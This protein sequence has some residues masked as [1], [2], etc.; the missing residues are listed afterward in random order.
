[1]LAIFQ[2]RFERNLS[3]V[4]YKMDIFVRNAVGGLKEK[5]EVC[6]IM[7]ELL[8]ILDTRILEFHSYIKAWYTSLWKSSLR[9]KSGFILAFIT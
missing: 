4:C 1:M 5:G 2:L 3:L 7:E 9:V 8:G 6:G